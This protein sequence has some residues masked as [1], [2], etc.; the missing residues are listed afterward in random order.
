VRFRHYGYYGTLI[1]NP[2]LEVKLTGQHGCMTT[3]SGTNSVDLEK[4]SRQYRHN[5]DR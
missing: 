4:V 5:Q 3:G 2:K 1:G